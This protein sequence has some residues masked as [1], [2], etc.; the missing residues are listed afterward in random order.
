MSELAHRV[1]PNT[2]QNDHG[3]FDLASILLA[4]HPQNI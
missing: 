3:L 1:I 4:G 2:R